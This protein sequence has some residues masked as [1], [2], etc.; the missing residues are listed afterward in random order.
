MCIEAG[1][2]VRAEASGRAGSSTPRSGPVDSPADG[3]DLLGQAIFEACMDSR[4]PERRTYGETVK[5]VPRIKEAPDWIAEDLTRPE[6][7]STDRR[8]A[9]L[10]SGTAR[11]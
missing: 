10:R 2:S 1:A 7:A 3:V 8:T 11:M 9:G 4:W 6:N 5:A